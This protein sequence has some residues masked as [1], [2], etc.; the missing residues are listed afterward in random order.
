MTIQLQN[1]Y[2]SNLSNI[3][4]LQANGQQVTGAAFP[5]GIAGRIFIADGCLNTVLNE[6]DALVPGSSAG[7]SEILTVG[8]LGYGNYFI[9]FEFRVDSFPTIPMSIMQIMDKGSV[10]DKPIH[11]LFIDSDGVL[12][13]GLIRSDVLKVIGSVKVKKNAWN[14][15][16]LFFRSFQ[17]ATGWLHSMLNGRTLA[18]KHDINFFEPSGLG[19]YLKNGIYDYFGLTGFGSY[20]AKY[21]NMKI[22]SITTETYYSEMGG[23]PMRSL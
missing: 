18:K 11:T 17:D 21:R 12:C 23:Y 15:V 19:P 2:S 20:T 7:R 6:T 4:L 8:P 3:Q 16:N 5:D 14:S 10:T 9:E 22:S 13:A 1:T